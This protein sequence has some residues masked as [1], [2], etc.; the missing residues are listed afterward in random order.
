M[1]THDLVQP[2]C[3]AVDDRAEAVVATLSDLVRINTVNPYSGGKVLGSEKPGQLYL[4]PRLA[5]LGARVTLSEVPADVYDRAGIIGPKGRNFTDRPNLAAEFD[6]GGNGPHVL[7]F[8]HMD[9]VAADGMT[10]KPFEPARSGG[11]IYG[12]GASDDKGGLTQA[13]H[14]IEAL[15]RLKVPLKGKLTFASVI[16]EECNGGG[17]GIAALLLGGCRPDVAVCVD[18]SGDFLGRG[19]AG[20]VTGHVDVP[21]R[22]GHAA[23]PDGVS[24]LEK[25]LVVK[26]ALD[27]YKAAR[28]ASRPLGLLNIGVFRAGVHPAVVPGDAEME[29]NLVYHCDEA[30]A[31]RQ[32]GLGFTAAA[33]RRDLEH[34]VADAAAADAFLVDHAPRLTWVKDL[35]PYETPTD[36][37]LVAAACDAWRKVH[38]R[39]P[40]VETM[41]GWS[42]AA[43]VPMLAGCEVINLGCGTTSVVHG[44]AEYVEEDILIGHTKILALLLAD[45]LRDKTAP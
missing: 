44:P 24:A 17:A 43:Y 12:R 20:V 35:P 21:G 19:G 33:L 11:R 2:I 39:P 13:L 15:V 18:G 40:A 16:E 36:S 14:A 6:F 27:R 30:E 5:A 34:L 42:D 1:S 3:A 10:I 23:S 37:P 4:K 38:G 45:L 26:A 32:A 29:F 9:T 8:G 25:A 7:V 28:E 41:N 22:A 31:A